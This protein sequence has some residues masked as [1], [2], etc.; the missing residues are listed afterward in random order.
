MDTQETPARRRANEIEVQER[1]RD[2]VK[3]LMDLH[4]NT[5][6]RVFMMDKYNIGSHS[7]TN[8]IA[9]AHEEIKNYHKPKIQTIINSHVQKYHQIAIDN[10][11]D[12]PRTT[13][14]AMQG[15]EKLLRLTGSGEGKTYNTQVNLNLEQVETQELMALLQKITVNDDESII[16]VEEI[17]DQDGDTT[18]PF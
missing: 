15:L 3:M 7:V 16:D 11:E 4:N 1:T 9:K 5:E 12:D 10:Q 2:V 13:I 8:Y 17:Q 18:P 6:I 14:L